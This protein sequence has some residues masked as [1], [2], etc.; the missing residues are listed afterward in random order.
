[1]KKV[2]ILTL[3]C[4]LALAVAPVYAGGCGQGGN[5]GGL[6]GRV[7][8]GGGILGWRA[9]RGHGGSCG[10]QAYGHTAV[11]VIYV[12]RV[13]AVPAPEAVPAPIPA[14]P[15]APP[16]QSYQAP[17][18]APVVIYRMVPVYE[19]GPWMRAGACGPN[20]CR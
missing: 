10:Q 17:V 11:Q 15:P 14:P 3:L 8:L 7:G 20:G 19:R 6:F 9:N 18:Q 4:L 1:M 16:P 5:G 13:N 2:A 12:Q